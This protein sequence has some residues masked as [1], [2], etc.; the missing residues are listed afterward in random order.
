M[1]EKQ[2]NQA[3]ALASEGNGYRKISTVLGIPPSTVKSFLKRHSANGG[4]I[5]CLNCGKEIVRV[6][7]RKPKKFCSDKCRWD[8]WNAHPDSIN[9]KAYHTAVCAFCGKEFTVYGKVERTYCSRECYSKAR[10]KA[11]EDRRQKLIERR[12][13]CRATL[14]DLPANCLCT[15][16]EWFVDGERSCP[17]KEKASE[18][19]QPRYRYA[20]R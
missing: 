12:S 1:T 13:A 6:P 18:T 16:C 2:R 17:C 5:M 14:Q 10:E 15:S 20:D 3:L 19:V 4:S 9:R 8:W 7:K 11:W